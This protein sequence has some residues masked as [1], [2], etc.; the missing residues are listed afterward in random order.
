MIGCLYVGLHKYKSA[1][2]TGL[3]DVCRSERV[4][5]TLLQVEILISKY[6]TPVP[7][8]LKALSRYSDIDIVFRFSGS[9][10]AYD[11]LLPF[12]DRLVQVDGDLVL[13]NDLPRLTTVSGNLTLV[14]Q[15][16]VSLQGLESLTT[17]NKVFQ[18]AY[19][20]TLTS[21]QGLES[22]TAV[23][24]RFVIDSCNALTSLKGLS[25]L[26]TLDG[27]LQ[28]ARC[29]ALTSLEGLSGLRTLGGVLQIAHCHA[30]TSVMGLSSLTAV[31]GELVGRRL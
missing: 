13:R 8:I 21:L 3:L 5:G 14:R 31:G 6:Y 11:D 1:I 30:L 29:N 18:I 27:N 2:E 23:N 16:F 15:P 25:G 26:L 10:A 4:P 28:I 12:S 24:E 22:L 7:E 20:G 19:C 9:L 17:V